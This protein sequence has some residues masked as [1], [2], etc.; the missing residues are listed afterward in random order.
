MISR[1]INHFCS[2]AGQLEKAPYHLIVRQWP[3]PALPKCPHINN[4][5]HQ[6]QALTLDA[7]EECSKLLGARAAEP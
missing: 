2:M 1:Y 3:R 4:V 6:V 5:A 7:L